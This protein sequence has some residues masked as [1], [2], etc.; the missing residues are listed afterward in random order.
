MESLPLFHAVRG[1]PVL[2]VGE[3]EAADAKRR[4]IEEAG[5]LPTADEASG[6]RLAFVALAEGAEAEAARLKALGFLVNVVDRPELC[7]FTVPAIVDRA[8]VTLAIGTAGFSASL[9]KALKERLEWLL[10][11]GLGPL[12]RAIRTSRTQVAEVHGNVP[13]RRAFWARLLAPGGAL[14]PLHP[15]ADPASAIREALRSGAGPEPPAPLEIPVPADGAD[16]LTLAQVRALAAADWVLIDARLADAAAAELLAL[17]RRDAA[18]IRPS[19]GGPA[20]AALPPGRG[21]CLRAPPAA[22]PRSRPPR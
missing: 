19:A 7:D 16:A 2:L 9:A 5:G 20:A 4:L 3:G 15:V 18:R 12:A 13:A 11:P 1:R 8:P 10:P 22:P 14:D 21:V 17:A 6:A